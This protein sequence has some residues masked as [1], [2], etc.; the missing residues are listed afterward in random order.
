MKNWAAIAR[1]AYYL[2]VSSHNK[3][4]KAPISVVSPHCQDPRLPTSIPSPGVTPVVT[5]TMTSLVTVDT[6]VTEE[7]ALVRT[8]P[9]HLVTVATPVMR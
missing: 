8:V 2:N 3:L 6:L 7:L 1:L 5:A 4:T 9:V